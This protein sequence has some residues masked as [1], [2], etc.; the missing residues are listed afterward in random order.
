MPKK[1]KF[2]NYKKNLMK[3]KKNKTNSK[4]NKRRLMKS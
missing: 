4:T 1:G 2:L 3:L